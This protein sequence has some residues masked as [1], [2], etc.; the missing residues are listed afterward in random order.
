MEVLTRLD[1]QPVST[2]AAFADFMTQT[3]TMVVDHLQGEEYLK[4][5]KDEDGWITF[6]TP[7][8]LRCLTHDR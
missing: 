8:I 2:Y 7:C 1:V 5:V 4:V 6:C 3:T